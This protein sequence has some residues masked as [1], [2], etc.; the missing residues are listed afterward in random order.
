MNGLYEWLI[1]LP[2]TFGQ[3]ADWLNSEISIGSFS[4]TPLTA[5]GSLAVGFVGVLIALKIK[6]LILA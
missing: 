2:A 6:S 1:G 4:F 5:L 3:F